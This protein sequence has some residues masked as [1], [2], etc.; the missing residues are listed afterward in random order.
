LRG[1]L[2]EIQERRRAEQALAEQQRA[3]ADLESGTRVL[4]PPHA[5]TGDPI[6]PAE[7]AGRPW[8][9]GVIVAAGLLL[10]AILAALFLLSQPASASAPHETAGIAV[11]APM[12][13]SAGATA[14]PFV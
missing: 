7:A 12:P 14:R 10:L 5:Q 11:F 6:Q 2:Q 8:R 1:A 13:A 4:I 9:W 3:T